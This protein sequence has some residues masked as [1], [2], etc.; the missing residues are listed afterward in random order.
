MK[1]LKLTAWMMTLALIW[2]GFASSAMA[3]AAMPQMAMGEMPM[4]AEM[5]MDAVSMKDCPGHAGKM[6]MDM[7]KCVT[8]C[9]G[10]ASS[11][12]I[13]PIA[14]FKSLPHFAEAVLQNPARLG[15]GRVA[16][17]PTPP[18]NFV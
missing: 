12:E 8:A 17:V 13:E 18:P 16:H 1:L 10:L 9:Y 5:T 6:T 3:F 2:V 14:V 15:D 11:V 4:A 7:S